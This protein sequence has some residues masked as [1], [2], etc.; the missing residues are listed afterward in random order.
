MVVLALHITWAPALIIPDPMH[1]GMQ[2]TMTEN[3]EIKFMTGKGVVN[4]ATPMSSA[5]A[6]V[7]PM[8]TGMQYTNAYTGGSAKR[9]CGGAVA[10]AGKETSPETASSI[11]H[12]SF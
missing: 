11:P 5:H 4:V 10:S 2:G 9:C 1:A 8:T 3:T 6:S 12:T 7:P